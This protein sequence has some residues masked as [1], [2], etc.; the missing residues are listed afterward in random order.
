VGKAKEKTQDILRLFFVRRVRRFK[1]F[2][3]SLNAQRYHLRFIFF[4]KIFLKIEYEFFQSYPHLKN[5]FH[6]ICS[7]YARYLCQCIEQAVTVSPRDSDKRGRTMRNQ[8][9]AKAETIMAK[10]KKAA[11]KKAKKAKKARR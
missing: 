1:L 3:S 8:I 4:K 6:C 7:S 11:K 10:K 9:T 2:F 5:N